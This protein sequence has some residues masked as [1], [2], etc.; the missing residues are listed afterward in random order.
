MSDTTITAYNMGS[1]WEHY[2]FRKHITSFANTLNNPNTTCWVRIS[3]PK[4][5]RK[6]SIGIA[7]PAG[8]NKD[9][10]STWPSF[11]EIPA[12]AHY[13]SY[14]R[15]IP[16]RIDIYLGEGKVVSNYSYSKPGIEWLPE[17]KGPQTWQFERGDGTPKKKHYDALGDEIQL[18]DFG[19]YADTDGTIYFGSVTRIPKSGAIYVTNIKT[20]KRSSHEFRLR[21]GDQF[22][23]MTKDIFSRLMLLKLGQ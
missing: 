15:S 17:Y 20:D 10:T 14:S 5:A 12:N 8:F 13:Y 18:G 23:R 1:A 4:S 11:K 2:Q 3:D 22:A 16:S 9:D 19:C 21:R 6:G 7:V